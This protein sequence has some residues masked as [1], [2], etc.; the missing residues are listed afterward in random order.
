MAVKQTEPGW[1]LYSTRL[2][3][4]YADV[5]R[6]QLT[7]AGRTARMRCVN[8]TYYVEVLPEPKYPPIAWKGRKKKCRQALGSFQK[9]K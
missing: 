9:Q 2:S 7:N 3:W 5:D 4:D 8:G 6:T 1:E